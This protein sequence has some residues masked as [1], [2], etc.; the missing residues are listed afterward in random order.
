MKR[1]GVKA[2]TLEK[3]GAVS[4]QTAAE[5]AEGIART[6]SISPVQQVFQADEAPAADC[7]RQ[8]EQPVALILHIAGS[9]SASPACTGGMIVSSLI[10][11][12][13][14][15]KALLEGC[16]TYSNEAQPAGYAKQTL[17]PAFSQGRALPDS[18]T[19]ARFLS[20]APAAS[21]SFS[22]DMISFP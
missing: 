2:E 19:S 15:S 22:R 9:F 21:Q 6:R 16:V 12:A 11:Y 7:R 13:G 8:Q 10:E 14:I 5:M 17:L 18:K 20:A 4:P 1:L 3:Y